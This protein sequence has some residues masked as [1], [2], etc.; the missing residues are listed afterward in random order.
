MCPGIRHCRGLTIKRDRIMFIIIGKECIDTSL[1]RQIKIY[2]SAGI[3]A[4]VYQN[5]S[6]RDEVEL[7]IAFD[8]PFE[9]EVAFDEIMNSYICGEPIF[10]AEHYAC[11]PSGLLLKM[12]R[13]EDIPTNPFREFS[14]DLDQ[15]GK[16]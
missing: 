7:P 5:P 12:K 6:T 11:V 2:C 15:D 8:D 4:M 3:I 1:F 13:G 10:I 9:A 14:F 16:E